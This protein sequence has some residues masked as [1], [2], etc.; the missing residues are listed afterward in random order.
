MYVEDNEKTGKPI[1]TIK[2]RN[3][4]MV[5]MQCLTSAVDTNISRAKLLEN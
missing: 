1:S 5:E 3:M 4:S 2:R